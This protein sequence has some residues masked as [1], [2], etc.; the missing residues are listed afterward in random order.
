MKELLVFVLL[1]LQVLGAAH[2]PQVHTQPLAL[3]YTLPAAGARNISPGTALAFRQGSPLRTASVQADHFTVTGSRSGAHSGT[4]RLSDDGLTVL[5]YPHKPF[6]YGETVAVTLRDGLATAAGEPVAGASYHFSTLTRPAQELGVPPTDAAVERAGGAPA[7][8]GAATRYQTYPEFWNVMTATVTTPAQATADGYL[9]V[10]N[11]GF[12]TSFDPGVLILDNSGE[13]IWQILTPAG[14]MVT[15]LNKQVVGGVPYLTYNVAQAVAGWGNGVYY[16]LDQ[17]YAVVDSWTIGNGYGADVH[18]LRLLDNGHALLMSYVPIPY[19]LSPYGG[20]ADA[21]VI[22]TVLQEQ[23]STKNVVFEWHG[24]QYVPITDTYQ[25]LNQAT[26]DYMH[27]NAIELDHDGNLLVSFRNLSQI[28]KINRQTGDMI[29]R[30]GGRAN[31]FAISNDPG[32]SLQHD[33]RRLGNGHITLFDN[34]NQH[35]P[36]YSR[37]VEYAIDE[38]AMTLTRVWQYPEDQSLFAPFMGN[39][40]RLDNGNSLI[41]WGALPIVSEVRPDGSKAFE[42]RLGALSYRA[43]RH[44]WDA[45]PAEAPRLSA[46]FGGDPTAA[47]VFMAWNGATGISGYK[48]FAGQTASYLQQVASVPRSGFE[49]SA[50]L[51]GLPASTC[52]LRMQPTNQ[53][54]QLLPFSNTVYRRDGAACRSQLSFFYLPYIER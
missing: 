27:A 13:P 23:D 24:S 16:V 44:I 33:I 8:A 25:G 51:T 53:Q 20:P 41:G 28:I 6:A 52:V 38:T 12:G 22:E 32:F 29:W 37:A 3:V 1:A 30:L 17:H 35:K 45:S 5:F 18:D 46:I 19:D 2:A 14:M 31:Q 26:L 36:P 40:Q 15:D 42:M 7:P 10:A 43:Q 21:V 48:V 50:Q 47:S 39:V 9:F 11:M 54:G 49:T 34:G 4:A